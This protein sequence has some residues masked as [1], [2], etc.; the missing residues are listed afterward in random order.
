MWVVPLWEFSILTF[1]K[2]LR[3]P[4]HAYPGSA[5]AEGMVRLEPSDAFSTPRSITPNR[6]M[7]PRQG[8]I[9]LLR[10]PQRAQIVYEGRYRRG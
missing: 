5:C 1:S 9:F 3:K 4:S 7:A 2:Y 10:I 8:V 6:L